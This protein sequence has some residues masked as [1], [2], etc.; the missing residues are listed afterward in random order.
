MGKQLDQFADFRVNVR[1]KEEKRKKKTTE[2]DE[3]KEKRRRI[4]TSI[5][6]ETMSCLER[7]TSVVRSVHLATCVKT[8]GTSAVDQISNNFFFSSL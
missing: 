1:K 4:F 7:K 2:K 6:Y 8:T 5:F 3:E